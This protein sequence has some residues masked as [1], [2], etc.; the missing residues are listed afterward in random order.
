M[1]LECPKC[2]ARQN[3]SLYDSINVSIDPSLKEKLFKGEINVFQCEKCDQK[4]FVATPLL[5]YDMEKHLM[6]QFYPFQAIDDKE[7]LHQFSKE[8]EYSNEMFKTLPKELRET[9]KR[10]HFVFDMEELIRF[11]V[12]RDKLHEMWNKA[13]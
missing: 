10:I 3:V 8:G 12:F 7:F 2:G 11:V 13:S 5:Y 6:I 1:E 4:I 9:F